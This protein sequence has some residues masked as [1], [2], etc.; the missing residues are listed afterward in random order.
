MT[1]TRDGTADGE[2]RGS[3]AIPGVVVVFTG[4]H[5][6]SVPL[7]FNRGRV[8]LGRGGASSLCVSDE[9]MSREHA[10]IRVDGDRWTVRDLGS[11]NGTFVDGEQVFGAV[12]IA[13][14]RVVRVGD[15]L[16]VPCADVSRSVE[17][18]AEGVVTGFALRDALMAIDRAARTSESLLLRGESGTGKELAARRYHAAG[19]R[20]GGRFIAVNCAAIPEG[21]AERLLFGTK[22]GA[23]SGAIADAVGHIES[24]DGGV[25]F[26]DE[27]GELDL[28]VQAKLLRVLETREVVPLGASVGRRVELHVCFATHRDLRTLVADGRFRADLYHR[29]SP[30]EVVLPALR[31]RA[32]EIP[33]HVAAEVARGA[34]DLAPHVRLVETCILRAWPGNVRELRKEVF[35]AAV[36]ARDEGADRVRSDHL[37]PSAGLPI[38]QVVAP[39]VEAVRPYVRWSE[40]IGADRIRGAL[41]ESGG[42][43]AMAARVL[44]MRRTQLYREME[45]WSIA[46]PSR[47]RG[48]RLRTG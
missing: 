38:A 32:D 45:R 24:A 37:S 41:E 14:P 39:K 40:A 25:L 35:H 10:E 29:I 33:R 47:A 44:G 23:Y 20:A 13:R 30:P 3:G 1:E 42:N 7:A 22:K 12:E 28:D 2:A 27:A 19:P 11:R 21:L 8:L 5:P 48:E 18:S 17:T 4:T 6:T 26:L 9:R 43:V 46:T 36:R 31:E 15:T 16:V 34:G